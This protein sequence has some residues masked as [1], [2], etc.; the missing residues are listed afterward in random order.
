MQ[1]LV[2]AGRFS[3]VAGM[4]IVLSGLPAYEA[5][6]ADEARS[7]EESLSADDGWRRT[8]LGWERTGAWTEPT[9]HGRP[10]DR[11]LFADENRQPADRWDFHPALLVGLQLVAVTLGFAAWSQ[12]SRISSV[13]FRR[14]ARTA[15]WPGDRV[16]SERG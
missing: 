9:N 1:A 3:L 10:R 16:A 12:R 2:W 15:L 11:F 14:G 7:A 8:A 13:P 6:A 4:A 5:Q